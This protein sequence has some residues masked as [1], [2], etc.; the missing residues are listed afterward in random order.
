MTTITRDRRIA[1]RPAEVW[2]V[3]ADFDAIVDWVDDIDHSCLTTETATGVGAARRVQ[4]GSTAVVER[5]ER[6]EPR[7][8]LGYEIV[9]LP[10]MV[11]TVTNTWVLTPLDDGT[12]VRLTTRIDSSRRPLAVAIGRAVGRRLAATSEHMLAGL[13]AHLTTEHA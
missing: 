7:H 8:A 3:L 2:N 4:L 1:A 5:I 11:G 6:W 10:P 13:D 9:G 12:L